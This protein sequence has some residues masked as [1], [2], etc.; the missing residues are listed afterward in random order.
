L[1]NLTGIFTSELF[2]LKGTG[3]IIIADAEAVGEGWGVSVLIING[4][5]EAS[6]LRDAEYLK[7]FDAIYIPKRVITKINIDKSWELNVFFLFIIC[8]CF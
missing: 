8:L 1:G 4:I 5:S 6:G 2:V 7:V 3:L